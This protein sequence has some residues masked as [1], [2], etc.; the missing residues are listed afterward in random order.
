MS[1][2]TRYYT[3]YEMDKKPFICIKAKWLNQC[4]FTSASKYEIQ[5]KKNTLILKKI[6]GSK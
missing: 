5:I 1:K 3:V 2:T 4:G 6:K